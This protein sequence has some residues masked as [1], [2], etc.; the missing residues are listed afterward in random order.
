MTIKKLT[1]TLKDLQAAVSIDDLPTMVPLLTEV[2]RLTTEEAELSKAVQEASSRLSGRPIG[3]FASSSP[4]PTPPD[5]IEDFDRLT[6]LTRDGSR[7]L[8]RLQFERADALKRVQAEIQRIEE[9]VDGLLKPMMLEQATGL[10]KALEAA[11]PFD[12][13]LRQLESLRAKFLPTFGY[14]S[15]RT[16]NTKDELQQL[17]KYVGTQ[18]PAPIYAREKDRPRS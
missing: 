5:T 17:V 11:V 4:P 7:R 14:S 18:A 3:A 1:L 2:E 10:T 13:N 16:F 6:T 8:K 15:V 12:T 9:V